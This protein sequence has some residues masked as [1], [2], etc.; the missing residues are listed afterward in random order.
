MSLWYKHIARNIGTIIAEGKVNCKKAEIK[1]MSKM[2][3]CSYLKN[4]CYKR[5]YLE[6]SDGKQ[7]RGTNKIYEDNH[8]FN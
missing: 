6:H 4:T 5:N 3:N 2:Q 1:E 8:L 7:K